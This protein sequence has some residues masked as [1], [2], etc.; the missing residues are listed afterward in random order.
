[1]VLVAMENLMI[2]KYILALFTNFIYNLLVQ[3]FNVLVYFIFFF[4]N[5]ILYYIKILKEE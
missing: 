5:K 4:G 1:M 3:N 2:P